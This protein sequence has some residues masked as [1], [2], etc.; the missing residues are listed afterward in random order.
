MISF[1]TLRMPSSAG[2]WRKE[3]NLIA[4][5]ND[6]V[7]VRDFLIDRHQHFFLLD[8]FSNVRIAGFDCTNNILERSAIGHIQR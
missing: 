6:R 5:M 4:G 2:K 8:Q 7:F 3:R 1:T